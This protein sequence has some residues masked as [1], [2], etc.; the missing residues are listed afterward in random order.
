MGEEGFACTAIHIVDLYSLCEHTFS[1]CL[2]LYD[3]VGRVSG[4]LIPADTSGSPIDQRNVSRSLLGLSQ[5]LTSWPHS[6]GALPE[7]SEDAG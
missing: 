5:A 6:A 4:V 2:L 3:A 1:V 7:L